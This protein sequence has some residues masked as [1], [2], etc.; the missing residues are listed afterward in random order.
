MSEQRPTRITLCPDGPMLVRGPA[1]IEA[2]DGTT[3]ET[4]RPVSAVCRCGATSRAP[5]CDGSHQVLRARADRAA[6]AQAP[7]S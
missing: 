4:T 1:V 3:Y 2:E 5:W 6:A 7:S